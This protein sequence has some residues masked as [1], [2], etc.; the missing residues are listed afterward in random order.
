MQPLSLAD[1]EGLF[2]HKVC[3]QAI[4]S[5]ELKDMVQKTLRRCGGLPLA[6]VTFA[7]LFASNWAQVDERLY[8]LCNSVQTGLEDNRDTKDMRG[9]LSLS[10]CDLPSQLKTCLLYLS[11][12][13]EDHVIERD[14]LIRR[15]IAEGFVH[16]KHDITLFQLGESYFKE[17]INRNLIQP[18]HVGTHGRWQDCKVH[19]MVLEFITS[20]SIEENFVTIVNN[21]STTVKP[22]SLPS[23]IR[24]LSIQGNMEKHAIHHATKEVLSHVRSLTVF[25]KA[26]D[27]N[28][29]LSNFQLLHVLELKDCCSYNIKGIGSLPHLRYLRLS[30][31]HFIE[32]PD[33]TGNLQLLQTLD[34]KQAIVKELPSTLIKLRQ[35]VCLHVN[36]LTKLPD[37]IGGMKSLEVLS[38]ID[39]SKY[40][41]LLTELSNL[42]NLRVL[43]MSLLTWHESYEKPL[44]ECLCN[45]KKLQTLSIFTSSVSLDFLSAADFS[46]SPP[47]L[48]RRFSACVPGYHENLFEQCPQVINPFS[49]LPRWINSSLRYL[50]D[51]S[52]MVSK[53]SQEDLEILKDLPTLYSLDLHVA[54]GTREKLMINSSTGELA[55]RCLAKFKFTSSA[56]VLVFKRGAMQRLQVLLLSFRLKETKSVLACFQHGFENLTSLKAVDVAINCHS[57][58][59]WE[60]KAAEDAIKNAINLNP[61]HP[62]LDITRYFEREM[63]WHGNQDITELETKEEGPV[64]FCWLRSILFVTH[65]FTT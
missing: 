22:T 47:Q 51:L 27:L 1:S 23:K 19:D 3:Q 42:S 12:F 63:L 13:P 20:L 6:I 8:S 26:T 44:L 28:M 48:L 45:L 49:T 35:L 46:F 52:I 58:F 39:V 64:W 21:T 32:L 30:S 33:E 54:E 4:L 25:C 41:N 11:I 29:T 65:L 9:I 10:Y 60:V 24:R 16:A 57:A 17:L 56:M 15:W 31:T 36:T 38:E 62:T 34:L 43:Q 14:D 5:P 2:Y 53:L 55:F 40:P 7:S 50:S 37:G 18:R 59:L 61:N